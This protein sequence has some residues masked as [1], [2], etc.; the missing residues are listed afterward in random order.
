MSGLNKEDI[1]KEL[2][3]ITN[4]LLIESG[5]V[6]NVKSGWMILCNAILALIVLARAELFHRIEKRFSA[7]LPDRLLMEAETLH[8]IATYLQKRMAWQAYASRNRRCTSAWRGDTRWIH[9]VKG[10]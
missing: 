7:A 9:N 4:Q 10:H 1:E 3:I 6:I 8:D 5:E 2:I